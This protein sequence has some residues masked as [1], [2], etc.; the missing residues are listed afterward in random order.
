MPESRL[1]DISTIELNVQL[2]SSPFDIQ[3]K[4]HVIT[5]ASCSGKTTMLNLIAGRG[6]Q[7]AKETARAYFERELAKGRPI[8]EI[9]KDMTA[10]QSGIL[11]LQVLLENRL[12]ADE[13]TFLD[14]AL[15]D[16]LTFHRL[17]GMDPNGILAGCFRHRYASVFI[18]DRLPFLREKRLGPEDEASATFVDRWLA[19]DYSALGYEV[20]RVPVLSPEDRL[21]FIFERLSTQGVM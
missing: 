1:S 11:E 7:T 12:Q 18:L 2:L 16:S 4:W 20:V 5:G 6:Y 14:R 9:R 19:R 17:V 13:I 21:D 15:P 3:T 10:I 8:D